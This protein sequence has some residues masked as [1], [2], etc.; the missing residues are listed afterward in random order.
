MTN[1]A[2]QAFYRIGAVSRLTG[3]PSNTI[4][5]WERRYGAVAPARSPGGGRLYSE[6]DIERLQLLKTLSRRGDAIGEIAGLS[7]AQLFDRSTRNTS[8]V[9]PAPPTEHLRVALLH[10]TLGDALQRQSAWE[11]VAETTSPDAFVTALT[12]Q[13][14]V[15]VAVLD[16][17][18]LAGEVEAAFE[19]CVE[20]TGAEVIVVTYHFASQPVLEALADAGARLL[21]API[22]LPLLER[23]VSEQIWTWAGASLEEPPP[24]IYDAKQLFQLQ[25]LSSKIDCECPHHLAQIVETLVSFEDYSA[26]C[27]NQSPEDEVIH[28]A[29]RRGTGQARTQMERLLAR[30][31][32]YEGFEL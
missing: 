20:A 13:P 27:A 1:R 5:T 26:K 32:E 22:Q 30:L 4:R 8:P 17:S 14:P 9:T 2:E 15:D 23:I 6:D 16:L 3:L 28:T 18:L 11:V 21:R 31:V 29:L 19:R 25:A 12:H 10:E 7:T 24:P